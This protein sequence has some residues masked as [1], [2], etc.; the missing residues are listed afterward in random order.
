ML[1]DLRACDRA[2][3]VYM[4]DQN[5]RHPRLLGVSEKRGGTFPHLRH[6]AGR[7]F[8]IGRADGLYGVYHKQFG[9]DIL[10][11]GEN[12]VKSGLTKYECVVSHFP[13][14]VGTQSELRGRFLSR[15]IKYPAIAYR[16]NVL[17]QQSRFSYT[18][19]SAY[20]R[21]AAGHEASAKH[22]V[23]FFG[24]HMYTLFRRD[25]YLRQPHRSRTFYKTALGTFR[26]ACRHTLL[27]KSV[28]FAT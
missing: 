8:Y 11:M 21:E 5:D 28:P 3:L 1:E 27:D 20:Q 19:F 26:A 12:R 22:A 16:Q 13:E 6:T 23:Q 24:R 7:R 14:S 4:A 15:N 18:R 9:L 2:V 25:F 17:K 10:D